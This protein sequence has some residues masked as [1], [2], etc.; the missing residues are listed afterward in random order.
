MELGK[1][2]GG[3]YYGS[4]SYRQVEPILHSSGELLIISPYI[5]DYYASYLASHSSKRRVYVISSSIH[6]RTAKKLKGSR[7]GDAALA[8]FVLAAINA[9]MLQLGIFNVPVAV[10][11]LLIS[12]YVVWFALSH[13]SGV[14]LKVPKSFVHIKMYV[15][16]G[17]A[18]EGSA[19]LTYAGM[20]K[21]IEKVHVVTDQD[22]VEAMR[23]SF[24]RLWKSL[25]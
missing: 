4:G 9:L 24:W 14:R 11:S 17:T 25:E 2:G 19:N 1:G 13:R 3:A 5:D 18:A 7:I 21:N 6:Y 10:A 20:H 15:G 23:R 22:E 16:E 12:V 8:V